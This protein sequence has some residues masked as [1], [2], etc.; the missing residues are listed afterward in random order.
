[1]QGLNPGPSQA[2]QQ[3]QLTQQQIE[4]MH[5]L[6]AALQSNALSDKPIFSPWAGAARMADALVGN[7]TQGAQA[8]AQ[9]QQLKSGA[10]FERGL[11]GFFNP[12]GSTEEGAPTEGGPASIRNNNPG[13]Q[14]P[15]PVSQEFGATGSQ[16]LSD[17]NKI[18]TFPDPVHGA[19]AHLALL[20]QNYAGMPLSDA[21]RKWS[22]GNSSAEYAKSVEARTGLSGSTVITPE[23][24][25]SPQ[26]IELAKAMA[27]QEAGREFPLDD[28]GWQRAQGLAFV[29]PA[30]AAAGG[31][32]SMA[33]SP[34]ERVAADFAANPQPAAVPAPTL[35]GQPQVPT[36]QPRPASMGPGGSA[37]PPPAA[38]P[39]MGQAATPAP[40]A[41]LRPFQNNPVTPQPAAPQPPPNFIPGSI[42]QDKVPQFRQM[43]Y[44]A[45]GNPYTHDRAQQWLEKIKPTEHKDEQ[46]R[47]VVGDPI[48]GWHITGQTGLYET[49]EMNLPGHLGTMTLR[50]KGA[51]GAVPVGTPEESP[52][53]GPEGPPQF[54]PKSGKYIQRPH[55]PFSR[56]FMDLFGTPH[57]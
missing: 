55:D 40:P 28:S 57:T 56:F 18:A 13:A 52:N 46:G 42:P 50:P 3:Q 15:G 21:I 17:G 48:T 51:V 23:L 44:E 11:G 9:R 5:D 22:G 30:G 6:A 7:I 20:A 54:D 2:L 4:Q 45:L 35:G 39:T 34:N 12:S 32:T 26:G 27:H 24:L 37:A 19:A 49:K 8:N 10:D 43:V 16:N 47:T 36:P 41:P 29:R 38:P 31:S 1:M 53:S 25:Q 14:W 33:P